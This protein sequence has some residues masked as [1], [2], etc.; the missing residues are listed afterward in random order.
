[1]LPTLPLPYI[2]LIKP[3]PLNPGPFAFGK[4]FGKPVFG[5]GRLPIQDIKPMR[6]GGMVKRKRKVKK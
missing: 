2:P 3:S 1:M 4:P 5:F 6:K